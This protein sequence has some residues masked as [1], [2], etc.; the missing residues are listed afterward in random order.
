LF[1]LHEGAVLVPD[2]GGGLGQH[3]VDVV[4]CTHLKQKFDRFDHFLM[5][6]NSRKIL[7]QRPP[8]KIYIEETLQVPEKFRL[9][10]FSKN[11]LGSI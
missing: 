2:A 9:V 1:T 10:Y 11:K 3:G 4:D 7:I 6:S 5:V 8:A